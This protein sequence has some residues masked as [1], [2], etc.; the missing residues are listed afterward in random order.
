MGPA[1]IPGLL[2]II[3]PHIL[4]EGIH[5]Y[6]RLR[7]NVMEEVTLPQLT[8]EVMAYLQKLSYSESRINQ[9][10]SAWQRLASFMEKEG[11]Q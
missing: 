7:R 9:Y 11:V 4:D 10:R 3:S 2:Y 5:A 6:I 1:Y 8:T